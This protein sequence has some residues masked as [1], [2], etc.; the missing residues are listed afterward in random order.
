[1]RAASR[2]TLRS[3]SNCH[4]ERSAGECPRA[5]EGP[6]VISDAARTMWGQPPPAV[7]P[8]KA[9]QRMRKQKIIV[10]LSAAR[11]LRDA[12]RRIPTLHPLSSRANARAQSKDLV[13][14]IP[15]SSR[16]ERERMPA[17]SRGTLRSTSNCHSERSASEGESLVEESLPRPR[18]SSRAERE[19]MPARSRGTL[20]STSHCHPERSASACESQVEESLPFTR[21]HPERSASECPR[22]VEGPCVRHPIVILSA[23]RAHASR[24]SKNP[25]PAPGCHLG[26]RKN[27]MGTAAALSS[28]A[29]SRDLAFDIQLS[30]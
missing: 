3:T 13:F 12:S 4:S 6:C 25:Y 17:R 1:M 2:G 27:H 26:F 24:K 18:L 9:R 5:V 23:A 19:R 7:Q 22:A 20:R 8:S 14:G 29:Q 21:C 10:I 30:F 16:A 28:R 15:L 11:A